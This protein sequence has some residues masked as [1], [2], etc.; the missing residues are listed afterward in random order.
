MKLHKS[1]TN[2]QA[3]KAFNE[4][5]LKFLEIHGNKY[6]YSNVIYESSIKKVEIVCK[7]HGSFWQTPN[8]HKSGKGCRECAINERSHSTERVIKAFRE[9]HGNKYDYSKMVYI[10]NSTKIE[11]ICKKH[12]SFWVY[13]NNHKRK[14]CRKCAFEARKL[15]CEHVIER[16]KSVHGD[17]YDYSRFEYTGSDNKAKIIC[18]KHGVFEQ[19]PNQHKQGKGC[20]NCYMPSD[21]DAVY[22]WRSIGDNINSKNVYKIGHTSVRLG[23]KR[24][25]N[26]IKSSGKEAEIIIL[27]KTNGPAI[28]I[29]SKLKKIGESAGYSGFDGA[30]EFRVFSDAQLEEALDL[31]K[32]DCGHD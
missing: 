15:E 2:H 16:F 13:P 27:V 6:D 24:I 22:I 21:N 9:K 31:I 30:T 17:K 19:K 28:D 1:I 3:I 14:G 32:N 23:K 26:V 7:K 18:K 11:V 10:N 8:H 12:G 5:E 20:P 29:E 4:L 25:N